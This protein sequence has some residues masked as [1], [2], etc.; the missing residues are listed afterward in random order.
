M[1]D[2][3]D[4]GNSQKRGHEGGIADNDGLPAAHIGLNVLCRTFC[5]EF[6]PIAD[7]SLVVFVEISSLPLT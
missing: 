7:S 4:A 3:V 5:C 6:T 1:R 2:L